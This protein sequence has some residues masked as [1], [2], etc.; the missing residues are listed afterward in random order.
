MM[1]LESL[2]LMGGKWGATIHGKGGGGGSRF[3]GAWAEE[4]AAI[5][6]HPMAGRALWSSL[7]LCSNGSY[8]LFLSH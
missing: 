5:G 2:D 3:G 4:V 1:N 6:W 8:L 7:L